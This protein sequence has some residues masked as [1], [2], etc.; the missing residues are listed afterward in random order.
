MK[1]LIIVGDGMADYPLPELN[2]R[3]PLQ[4]AETPYMDALAAAGEVGLVR[5][6]APGLTPASDVAHLAIFGYDPRRCYTGRGP[7]EAAGMGIHLEKDDVAFRCNLVTLT[8]R[9]KWFFPRIASHTVLEDWRGGSLDAEETREIIFDLNDQLGTDQIQFYPGVGYRN[10]MVWAGGPTVGK[11]EVRVGV[12]HEVCGREVGPH[13]PQG[14]GTGLLRDLLQAAT[15]ILQSHPVNVERARAG[16]RPANGIWLWGAGR[17]TQL[18]RFADRY[19]VNGSVVA[20]VDL[21]KG[22]AA[23]AGLATVEVPGA[24][25]G[26]DTD[27]RAKAEA[28]IRELSKRDLVCIHVEAPDEAS[29]LGDCQAKIRAIEAIDRDVVGEVVRRLGQQ[30]V[31]ILLL[32]DH[33]TSVASRVHTDDPV[34]FVIAPAML[35]EK[36]SRSRR[37]DEVEAAAGVKIAEG[38]RLIERFLGK[39]G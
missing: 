39:S 11:S 25:G 21:I 10:L 27:Y 20:A 8:T 35:P 7:L 15:A 14:D 2:G 28:A 3:T 17:R 31:K 18:P 26:L 9:G 13:L 1:Y 5:T 4:A 37:Y 33:R 30:E 32:P 29:H 12:P 6:I 23:C 36:V 24:T 16:E 19:G 38:Y 22:V 34:P